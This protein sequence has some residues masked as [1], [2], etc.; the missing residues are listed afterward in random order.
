MPVKV[1]DTIKSRSH[2]IL[3]FQVSNV[4]VLRYGK[5]YISEYDPPYPIDK[6]FYDFLDDL[7]NAEQVIIDFYEVDY[8]KDEVCKN[9]HEHLPDVEIYSVKYDSEEKAHL[10]KCE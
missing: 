6:S 10:E 1:A 5:K 2:G 8:D 3:C 9:I 4:V 7:K